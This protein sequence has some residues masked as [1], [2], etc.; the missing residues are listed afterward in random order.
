MAPKSVKNQSKLS[1]RAFLFSHRFLHR[2]LIDF[3]S[4]LRPA[5]SPKSLFFLKEKQG[6]FK[7]RLSKITSISA[8]ILVPTCLHVDLQPTSKIFGNYSLPRGLQNCI[9]FRID[10]LLHF[11]WIFDYFF[12]YFSIILALLFETCFLKIFA[13][14][15]SGY[16][17]PRNLFLTTPLMKYP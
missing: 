17:C 5:G 6:F 13:I 1:F 12:N 8:S 16:Y 11:L 3:C 15:A 4:Q 9:I 7:K 10:F 14:V 2:C